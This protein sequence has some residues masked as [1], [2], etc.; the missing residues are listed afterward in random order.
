MELVPCLR[1]KEKK[2]LSSSRKLN[3]YIRLR[4][5][6]N[7]VTRFHDFPGNDD[8]Y[9]RLKDWFNEQKIEYSNGRLTGD[10]ALHFEALLEYRMSLKKKRKVDE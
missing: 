6:K 2:S 9:Y 5:V 8:K 4:D 10:M 3:W 1:R 7:Y